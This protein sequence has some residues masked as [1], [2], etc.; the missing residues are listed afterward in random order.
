[1]VISAYPSYSIY[2]Q[3]IPAPRMWH[4]RFK[5]PQSYEDGSEYYGQ[6]GISGAG[7]SSQGCYRDKIWVPT[8][9]KKSP[10]LY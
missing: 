6:P 1:M 7:T 4:L 8:I 2:R 9:F 5:L 3:M 10:Y